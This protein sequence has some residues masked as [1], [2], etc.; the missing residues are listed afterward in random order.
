MPCITLPIDAGL[1]P[2]L[3]LGISAPLSL[4]PAGAPPPI[5]HWISAI[6]DTG[7]TNTSIYTSVATAAGLRVMGKGLVNTANGPVQCN[8]FLGDLFVKVPLA[9]GTGFEFFFRDRLLS[10]LMAK[11]PQCDALFGMDM[12]TMGTFHVNGITKNA[13]FCW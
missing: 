6:A 11:I 13:T 10:E 1:R 9:N 3:E 5:I 2:N 12:M 8:R 7:C 4:Q